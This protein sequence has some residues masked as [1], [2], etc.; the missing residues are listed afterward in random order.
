MAEDRVRDCLNL[1]FAALL[2]SRLCH[3]LVSP[4]GAI[5]NG[6]E[7]LRDEDDEEMRGQVL[8]LLEDS[9]RQTSN[10]LQFF[11][12]AFGAAGGFGSTL[13]AREAHKAAA[14]FFGGGKVDLDWLPDSAPMP[15]DVVKLVLNLVLIAS[16]SLIRGGRIA[17][18]LRLE[19]DRYQGC[20]TATGE[21][22]LLADTVRKALI[23]GLPRAELEPRSAPAQLCFMLAK[24]LGAVVRVELNAPHRLSMNFSLAKPA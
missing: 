9:A 5:G 14:N 3:D 11:R 21:R 18:D 17:V 12:L 15:K 7:I 2:C 23:E 19:D 8:S 10:R 20:I 6:V 13:D 1:D 22:L 16:E 4:V 24:A